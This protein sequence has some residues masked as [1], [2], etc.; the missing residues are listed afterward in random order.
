[1]SRS[2]TAAAS[3]S[4]EG[5]SAVGG[6]VG[7]RVGAYR[8]TGVIGQGGMAEVYRAVRDD[9][10]FR[11]EVAVKVVRRGMVSEFT[12]ARFRHERQ[13]LA[14]LEHPNIAR[15]LDGGATEDGLPYFVMECVEGR[16]I[17]EYCE[18][19]GLSTRR[20]LKLFRRV[21]A[22]VSYAHRNLI[23]HRDLKPS[24]VLVTGDGVPKLLDFG[25]AKLLAPESS[26]TAV[27]VARTMTAVRLMTPEYASPEQV[28]GET[29]TTAADVYSLGALLFELL[30]GE[31]AHKLADRSLA[32]IER[33]ICETEAERP[34][35]VVSRR[36]GVPFRLRRELAGDLDNIVLTA[37]RKEPD[38]RYRSA[39]QLSEDVRRYLEGR[40][41]TA[42]QDTLGYRAGKFVR[43]HKASVA[44]AV[45]VFVL[46]VGFAAAMSVQAAR[47][48]R[49]RD[50]ANAVTGFLVELFEVSDPGEARGNAITARELLDRGAVKIKDELRDQPEGQAALMDTMGSVYRKLGLY[51]SALPLAEEALRIRRQVHDERHADVAASLYNLATV[52]HAKG[53]Y[54]AAEP[55]YREALA[56]RR[57][58][59]GA[60]HAETAA[61]LNGLGLFL[62]D[63]GEYAEAEALLREA[64]AARRSLFGGEHA[65]VAETLNELGVLLKNRGDF[66]TAETLYREA[67]AMRRRTLGDDHPAV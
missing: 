18:A 64:L 10:Q 20:R 56:A 44:A 30:T 67:L 4:L 27:T 2:N 59:F 14:S 16:P 21:C 28:R 57:A 33:V 12:L 53:D 7:R 63:K 9:D 24:N 54:K 26:P 34:S 42:R 48:A 39:E 61:S 22:A 51:D 29:V 41:V 5:D 55:L 17:T 19:G 50:R 3:A 1:M 58:L 36:A 45:A 32:E 43:R 15:L 66:R 60:E 62:K 35:A 11:K 40:P 46:L 6:V 8:V 31:R 38:R 52:H 49:E 37:L 47:I 23:V 65:S 25:I 13:I